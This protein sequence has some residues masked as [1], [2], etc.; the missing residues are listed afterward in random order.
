MK[1]CVFNIGKLASIEGSTIRYRHLVSD[2]CSDCHTT[3][4]DP[5]Y[6]K[7]EYKTEDLEKRIPPRTTLVKGYRASSNPALQLA[8]R[9]YHYLNAVK[10]ADFEVAVFYN[11]WGT[12]LARRWVRKQGKPLVFDYIDLMHEF[13]SSKLEQ[14][15][16]RRSTIEALKNSDLVITT[17]HRLQEDALKY[18]PNSVL[19]PN[20]VDVAGFQKAKPLKL[21]HPAVGFA[22]GWGK[23]V[24]FAPILQ[25]AR[26]R[27]KVNFYLVGDGIQ[28]EFAERY[29]REHGLKNVYLTPSFVP[30]SEVRK[31]MA[32]FDV[33]LIPFH[34]NKLTDAVCPIKLFEYWSLKKPVIASPTYE[35][36]RIAKTGGVLFASTPEEW[37]RCIDRLLADSSLRKRLGGAGYKIANAQYDWGVLSRR[38]LA[39]LRDTIVTK[40]NH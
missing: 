7:S 33:C 26:A 28:R 27:P 3:W 12:Y 19:I 36:K 34:I 4:I 30:H 14:E 5:V 20:G 2:N 29:V 23:W 38:Y 39:A 25:A 15:V 21:K 18:N 35:M 16:S 6:H 24:D 9:E 37:G 11:S 40:K 22:G 32:A 17:A 1:I 31:W 13:R 8:Q 10:R